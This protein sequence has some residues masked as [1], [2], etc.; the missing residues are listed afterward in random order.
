MAPWRLRAS[1][2]APYGGSSLRADKSNTV[3]VF[4]L[5]LTSTG[6][7]TDFNAFKRYNLKFRNSRVAPWRLRASAQA[8]YGGRTFHKKIAAV[9]P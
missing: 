9:N 5:P 3:N 7:A 6:R 8:P 2:Q 4:L 1:A